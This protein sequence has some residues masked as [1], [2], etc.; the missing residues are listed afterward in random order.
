MLRTR[1][2][3]LR[4]AMDG[5]IN[6]ARLSHDAQT[7]VGAAL[8]KKSS[9]T[10]VATGYNGFV[11]MAKDDVLPNTRPDKY[12]YMLHSEVNLLTNCLKNNIS[13]TDCMVVVTMTPCK[14]C[15]RIM[16]QAGIE[17]VVCQDARYTDYAE[18]MSMRDIE[19]TESRS[20]E[21]FIV[22]N[23]KARA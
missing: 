8:V 11:R 21:G 18:M 9:M 1:P 13:I 22:L 3:K 6:T 14:A 23:Y 2:S 10:T 4:V 20:P 5:A 19:V 16:W 15:T 17:T 7:Q 12:E